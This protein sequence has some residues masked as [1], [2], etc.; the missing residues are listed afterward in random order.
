MVVEGSG[1]H[2]SEATGS[3]SSPSWL[4]RGTLEGV[5]DGLRLSYVAFSYAIDRL[6]RLPIAGFAAPVVPWVIRALFVAALAL[7]VL[8]MFETSPERISIAELAQGTLGPRQ[9]WIIVSGELRDELESTSSGYLYRL[10]DA[11]AP[12]AELDVHSPIRLPLGLTTVS[13]RIESGRGPQQPGYH[14]SARLEADPVL[15]IEQPPPRVPFL[16]AAMG[17]LIVLAARTTYPCFFAETPGPATPGLG[18]ISVV[19]HRVKGAS[20]VRDVEGALHLKAGV[21]TADLRLSGLDPVQVR[22]HSA[23]TN[24]DVG[25]LRGLSSS[26]PALRVLA[27]GDKLAIG[28]RSRQDRDAAFAALYAGAQPRP[29]KSSAA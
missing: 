13:G 18:P 16:L 29:S 6:R 20:G 5:I 26:E 3:V 21:A 4:N 27:A 23:F 17:L 1:C 19:A 10:T 22:L 2:A 11:A 24:L 12:N 15:A 9:T 7:L 8:W 25:V 28:F 14:W